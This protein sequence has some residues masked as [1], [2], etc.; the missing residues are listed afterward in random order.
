MAGPTTDEMLPFDAYPLR[1]QALL[2]RVTGDNCRRGYGLRFMQKTGQT[3]CAYCG[4]D[5][6]ASYENWLQMALDHV[7]PVSVCRSFSLPDDWT[8]DSSNRVLACA[9]C[10]TF[11]NRY[12]TPLSTECPH[13]LTDFYRLRDSIFAERKERVAEKHRIE[14]MFF[15]QRLWQQV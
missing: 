7:V 8:E 12:K 5:F 2:G 1:G 15:E 3:T 14:R 13:T 9:A 11:D 10:N 4:L 6:A